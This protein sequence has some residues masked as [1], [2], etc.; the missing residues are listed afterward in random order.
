[1]CFIEA[2]Q[3]PPRFDDM[4]QN[5]VRARFGTVRTVIQAAADRGELS[6]QNPCRT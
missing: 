3:Y 1:M 5:I 4:V 6:R 2:S